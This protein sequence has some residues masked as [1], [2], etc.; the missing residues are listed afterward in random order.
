MEIKKP[1]VV[2]ILGHVDHGKTTLLDYIRKSNIASREAGRITQKIGAYEIEFRGEKITFIDTPGHLAFSKLRERGTKVS[3]IGILVIAAD[4]GVQPQTKE[5]LEFLRIF[6]IPYIIALNKID[7][8][9]AEPEKVI[10]E[11]VELNVIPEKWGGEVPVVNISAKTGEG[12]DEILELILLLRDLNDL[13]TTVNGPAKGVILEAI[14]DSKRG[15]L[16]SLIVNKGCLRSGDIIVTSSTWGK[17]KILEDDLSRKI[18]EAYPSKPVLVGNFESLP[19]AGEEFEVGNENEIREIQEVLRENEKIFLQRYIFISNEKSGDFLLIIKADHIGSLEALDYILKNLA[20]KHSLNLKIIK[21]DL[22]PL[23]L[24]DITL[25]KEL[26][27]IVLSFNVKNS[28]TIL[29]RAKELK[30]KILEANVIYELE[31]K[32]ENFLKKEDSEEKIKGQ[33]IVL[34]TFSKTKTKKTIGGKVERGRIKL[35][36][37]IIILREDEIIGRGK[38]ISLEKNRM[39]TEEVISGELCGLVVE[40]SKDIEINDI[41]KVE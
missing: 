25:A 32:L 21:Q 38:I 4:E 40:T 36:D 37:K 16:A 22:G 12:V 35:K 20:S 19:L 39:P 28:K 24:Q 9:E 3:D 31:E 6:K 27:A 5:S 18:N 30:I 33:L 2:T 13:R 41:I 1:P 29:D 23:T 15:N 11:L 7:K 34:A 26:N 14:K 8:K 10:A 17:I